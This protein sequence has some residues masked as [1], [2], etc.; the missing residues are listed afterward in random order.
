[1]LENVEESRPFMKI[2]NSTGKM[3]EPWGTPVLIECLL[4]NKPLTLKAINLSER[5]LPI[6][7]MRV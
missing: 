2:M 6:L 3:T 4:K 7:L 5:K 1:M